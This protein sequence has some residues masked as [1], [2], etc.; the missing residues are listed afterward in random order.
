[1]FYRKFVS[2][3]AYYDEK[4]FHHLRISRGFTLWQKAWVKPETWRTRSR[5]VR[6]GRS[7]EARP[8]PGSSQA[9]QGGH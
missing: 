4:D 8:G 9:S 2:V 1:M 3:H 5:P 6:R 7:A